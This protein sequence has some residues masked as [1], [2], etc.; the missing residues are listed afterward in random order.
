MSVEKPL[1]IMDFRT[2][3]GSVTLSQWFLLRAYALLTR[4]GTPVPAGVPA[5][6]ERDLLTHGLA[7]G[8]A[9]MLH[10]DGLC[11]L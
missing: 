1:A 5:I 9:L 4:Q 3:T 11:R 7:H 8:L 6:S 10:D 2:H